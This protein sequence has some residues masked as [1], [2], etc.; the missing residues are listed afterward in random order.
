MAKG[1]LKQASF[2]AGQISPLLLARNDL[3]KHQTG[4]KTARNVI[5]LPQGAFMKR[6]GSKWIW[7]TKIAADA[8]RVF[9]FEYS[10]DQAYVVIAGDASF[11][12]IKDY[13]LITSSP[14]SVTSITKANPAV[15]TYAAPDSYANGD[16]VLI[17]GGEMVELHSREFT[18]A[19]VNVG[20][21]TFELSGVDSTNYT[22]Y[23][24]GGTVA[25][26]Y[27][28]VSPYTDE[29][30]AEVTIAASANV[31]YFFHPDVTPYKLTRTA[32][33]S[34]S[35][36]ATSFDDGPW[37]PTNSDPSIQVR[38]EPASTYYPGKSVTIYANSDIFTAN[39]VGSLFSMEE[40]LFDQ[41][42]VSPWAST[43]GFSASVGAQASS[44]GHVYSLV[45]AGGGAAVT[46]TIA[47][48]HTQGDAWDNPTAASAY[49]KFRYLHSR[50]GVFRITAYTS[51]KQ[52]TADIVTYCPDGF[53]QPSKTITGAANDGSGNIRITSAAHGY[54]NG[55]FVFIASVGGT[56]EANGYWEIEDVATNTFDLKGSTFA[57]A[58]TAGGTSRRFATWLWRFGAFSA[59]R[60]Y[61]SCGTFYQDR[62]VLAGTD[63]QPDTAWTS[64]VS[65]YDSFADKFAGSVRDDMAVTFTLA[66][67]KVDRIRWMTPDSSGLLL[68]TAGAEW[69]VRP[70]ATTK[71]FAPGN[72]DA[73][74]NSWH[75]SKAVQAVQAG[76]ATMFVQRSGKKI[77]EAIFDAGV[78]RYVSNDLTLIENTITKSGVVEATFVR[79]PDNIVWLC[80]TDGELIG[81]T[82]DREQQIA[83]FHSH[84]L[85][86]VSD[87]GG[88][89]PMV[90]SVCSIP[91]P[92]GTRDDLYMIVKRYISGATVRTVEYMDRSW[93][94]DEG[95]IEDQYFVD[96]GATYDG[97]STSTVTGLYF[98]RGETVQ[99]LVD[100]A[101]HPDCVVSATGSITLARAGSVVQIGY[102]YDADGAMLPTDFGAQDGS[103][104]G[105]V[106]K[107]SKLK[108]WVYRSATFDAGPDESKLDPIVM[109]EAGDDL[110]TPTPLKSGIYDISWPD[111]HTMDEPVMVRQSKPMAL[112]VMALIRDMSVS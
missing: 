111:G 100:G 59:A 104:A 35:M 80:R 33:A 1:S 75:G 2:T 41:L 24:S 70:A 43:Q 30:L 77:M 79:A 96:G 40:I 66:S 91:S 97:S 39:H 64:V 78:D 55:D 106:K 37:A 108:I 107:V 3:A 10:T 105:R 45:D 112:A 23:V 49:K 81:L 69:L 36:V 47:P 76:S 29:Q 90:E 68:G 89:A 74:P 82:Y 17:A 94:I 67:P 11:R 63:S 86:G 6:P 28:I 54:A 21:N 87:S 48:S 8:A 20:A 61:P 32:D 109:R 71:P 60:G 34:W 15:V 16:R 62:L 58:Y 65:G 4:L 88:S 93:D 98:L 56:T 19:N 103:A 12:F 110:D 72:V 27:E 22:T 13:D 101:A 26:I 9:P 84:A 51:A 5:P 99:V 83:G 44:N 92:D 7:N 85:G 42:A 31:V 53:N 95:A 25:E 46:G 38:I 14:Q 52:V 18:V 102:G 50:S 57:N 73:K